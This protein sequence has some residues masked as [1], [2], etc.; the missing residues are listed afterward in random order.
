MLRVF[1]SISSG[2]ELYACK[3]AATCFNDLVDL[4]GGPTEK[5][6]AN[7][8]M[9]RVNVVEDQPSSRAENLIC[10]GKIKVRSKVSIIFEYK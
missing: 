1:S 5:I 7:E 8:L 2:K 3:S 6:R 10:G 4:M 9:S